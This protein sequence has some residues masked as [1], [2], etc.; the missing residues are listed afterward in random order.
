LQ[1]TIYI[2]NFYSPRSVKKF[3]TYLHHFCFSDLS[4]I[5]QEVLFKSLRHVH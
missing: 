4:D 3:N 5:H 1:Q 2:S